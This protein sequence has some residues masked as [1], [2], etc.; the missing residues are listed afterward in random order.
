MVVDAAA[1]TFAYDAGT[2]TGT[3]DVPANA[4][5]RRLDNS[6]SYC[7]V[8]GNSM[9]GSTTTALSLGTG[10]GHIS[11]TADAAGAYNNV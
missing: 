10:T 11:T 7:T 9:R 6:S 2:A 3:V 5:L 8:I 4:T 1:G